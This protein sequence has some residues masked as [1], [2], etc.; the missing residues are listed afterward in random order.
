M[1]EY[2]EKSEPQS[3]PYRR[4]LKGTILAPFPVQ[5]AMLQR[6]K[7]I[8]MKI[9]IFLLNIVFRR[10]GRLQAMKHLKCLPTLGQA[11]DVSYKRS[12]FLSVRLFEIIYLC[13]LC[14]VMSGH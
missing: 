5:R 7:T 11:S 1:T 4:F 8:E 12:I 13:Q 9:H 14:P 2:I 10:K 3:L 6:V